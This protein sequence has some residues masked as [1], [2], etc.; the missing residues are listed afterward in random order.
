MP[1]KKKRKQNNAYIPYQNID[2]ENQTIKVNPKRRCKE[3]VYYK[4]YKSSS[5]DSENDFIRKQS[6]LNEMKC[7]RLNKPL[8]KRAV[9][10]VFIPF[11]KKPIIKYKNQSILTY[12]D[13]DTIKYPQ[14]FDFLDIVT[15]VPGPDFVANFRAEDLF[16]YLNPTE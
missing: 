15:E 3:S 7:F 12:F 1:V 13:F 2:K 8:V 10:T 4:D 16:F 5:T 14:R 9:R 6:Q 11:L